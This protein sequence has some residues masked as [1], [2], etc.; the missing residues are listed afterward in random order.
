LLGGSRRLKKWQKSPYLCRSCSDFNKF[1]TVK[2]FDHRD[3]SGCISSDFDEIWHTDALITTC[4]G[5]GIA[6]EDSIRRERQ[7]WCAACNSVN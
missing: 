1:G 2:Q 3:R 7:F 6:R 5:I 4:P